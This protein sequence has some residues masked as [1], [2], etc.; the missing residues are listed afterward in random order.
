[1]VNNSTFAESLKT[2]AV[3]Q[4]VDKMTESL[5]ENVNAAWKALSE[6]KTAF[7]KAQADYDNAK[8]ARDFF[9]K[10]FLTVTEPT[11]IS[12]FYHFGSK[13]SPSSRGHFVERK[14]DRKTNLLVETTCTC[15]AGSYGNKCWARKMTEDNAW[16]ASS[17]TIRKDEYDARVV[18]PGNRI[19]RLD[20]AR[21]W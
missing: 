10:T 17:Y 4:V 3:K 6:S 14:A 2:Q 7:E 20:T 5:N 19:P 9:R 15:V 13:S 11:T 16:T 8:E 1:M 12:T 18:R 21:S